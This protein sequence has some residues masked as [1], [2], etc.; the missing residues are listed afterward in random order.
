MSYIS[1]VSEISHKISKYIKKTP[2]EYNER[3]SQRYNCKVYL[4]REDLQVVRSFKVRGALSKMIEIDN[5][6]NTNSIVCA[7]AGNHACGVAF[8]CNKLGI[9]G[10]IFLPLSTPQQKIN[11]IKYYGGD[12]CKLN[13][14]GN[15]FDDTLKHALEYCE[16]NK[17]IFIHPFDDYSVIAGQ[18]T[19]AKEICEELGS[20]NLTIVCPIGGGGLVAGISQYL[21]KINANNKIIG[22]HSES[23]P[24]MKVSLENKCVS[25]IEIKDPFIDGGTV[26]QIGYKTYN[27]CRKY[28]DD[29]M[30][31]PIG[32]ICGEILELY[33]ND[34]IIVEPTGAISSAGLKYINNLSGNVVCILSG[35]NNDIKRYSEIE[36]RYL[37]YKNLKHYYIIKFIQKPGELR[38]FINSILNEKDDIVRFEYLKKTEKEYGNVLLG[39]EV[40]LS[41]NIYLIEKRM[42]NNN[43]T[44]I[45]INDND[46]LF[47]YLI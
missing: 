23:S 19:I 45:K 47:S 2:I 10:E 20:N 40:Q 22:I 39:I 34:G 1:K 13:I 28:V 17:K 44:Y 6:N 32:E 27:I 25:K 7:S 5:N 26:S 30:S 3:L 42:E 18:A 15:I 37:R 41:E 21:K 24:S 46:I 4:K 8:S 31:I 14:I 16:I 9:K 12:K 43:Y 36:E 29:V 38:K 11:R 33:N 35:G